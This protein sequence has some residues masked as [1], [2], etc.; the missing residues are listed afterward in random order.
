MADPSQN[1]R[2]EEQKAPRRSTRATRGQRSQSLYQNYVVGKAASR[3]APYPKGRPAKKPV[4][5]AIDDD[6]PISPAAVAL[7]PQQSAHQNR[8]TALQPET[9]A[10][11]GSGSGSGSG[12]AAAS[13]TDPDSFGLSPDPPNFMETDGDGNYVV[14]LDNVAPWQSH[15]GEL[16]YDPRM[17]LEIGGP[18]PLTADEMEQFIQNMEERL[19][20]DAQDGRD[21]RVA[22]ADGAEEITDAEFEKLINFDAPE[23]LDH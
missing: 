3:P 5:P 8:N 4:A 16:Q 20:Q 21:A 19:A 22:Q 6:E 7:D 2:S 1:T 18:E 14:E 11:S 15:N 12:A 9:I 17:N 13:T 10:G 23:Q